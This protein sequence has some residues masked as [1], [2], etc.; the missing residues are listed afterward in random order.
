MV[1][2][3]G[4]P[5]VSSDRTVIDAVMMA[6]PAPEFASKKT[7]SLLP[8][9]DALPAP[10]LVAAQFVLPVAFQAVELPPPTQ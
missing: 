6:G 10:P 3:N 8:G 7:S 5:V 1:G 9:T 4:V 2:E